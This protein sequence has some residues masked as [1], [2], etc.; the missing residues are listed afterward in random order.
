MSTEAAIW[1]VLTGQAAVVVTIVVLGIGLKATLALLNYGRAGFD[2]RM[3]VRSSINGFLVSIPVVGGAT[4]GFYE[5]LGE[6]GPSTVTELTFIATQ[7][8][9]IVG[10]DKVAKDVGIKRKAPAQKDT[11]PDTDPAAESEKY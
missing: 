9:A 5:A 11:N 1:D 3:T 10:I 8:A 7:I 6:A 2:I 4:I